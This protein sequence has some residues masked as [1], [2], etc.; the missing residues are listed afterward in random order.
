[1]ATAEPT[2]CD[3]CPLLPAGAAHRMVGFDAPFP[4]AAGAPKGSHA[5][6]PIHHPILGPNPACPWRVIA[7]GAGRP[8]AEPTAEGTAR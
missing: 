4:G 3:A 2:V 5:P 6:K 7:A 1:M 8:E